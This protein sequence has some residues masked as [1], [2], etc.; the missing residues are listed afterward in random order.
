MIVRISGE[1]QFELDDEATKRLDQLDNE[2]VDALNAGD[3]GTF[4][5]RLEDTVN[6]VRQSGTPLAAERVVPSDVIIPP[7]DIDIDEARQFFTDE[8]LMA[9]LPA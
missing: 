9:P 3:A 7:T 4:R 8:G 6:F 2:L 1:G 5:Q